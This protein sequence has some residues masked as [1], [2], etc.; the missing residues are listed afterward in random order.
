MEKILIVDDN[1]T[2]ITILGEVLS[3]DY[4]LYVANNGEK[5]IN[6]ARE[7]M[8]DIILLDVMMPEMDGYEVCRI[9]KSGFETESIP[10]IF[11]TAKSSSEDIVRG[12]QEGGQDYVTKP[13]NHNELRARIRNHIDLKKMREELANAAHALE[14]ANIETAAKNLELEQT[15]DELNRTKEQLIATEKLA[16][17]GRM[18]GGIAHEINSPLSGVI[19]GFEM[20]KFDILDLN[21]GNISELKEE[22]IGSIEIINEGIGKIRNIVN[23]ISKFS[24]KY[25]GEK[26]T[27]NLAEVVEVVLDSMSAV[28]Q[29]GKIKFKY[30]ISKEIN[31]DFVGN[32]LEIII[33]NVLSNSVEALEKTE[34]RERTIEIEAEK[35]AKEITLIFRD[36]GCG[37]N[38]DIM[39]KIFD[40][41]FT[42]KKVGEGMGLGLAIV[43]DIVKKTGGEIVVKSEEGSGTEVV[44]V[45][46]E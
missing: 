9:L 43:H 38:K 32:E 5:A 44:I 29:K 6:L 27:L 25:S 4:R 1:P 33:G 8:P 19:T 45:L 30:L 18:T 15:I 2:N 17:V 11:I 28:L 23:S 36:N 10:I 14:N 3:R 12:F 21:S 13:F 42:T 24:D 39:S 7:I 37:I 26:S 34:Q 16:T 41:F 35:S 31:I 40:P 20:M 22:I 46:R